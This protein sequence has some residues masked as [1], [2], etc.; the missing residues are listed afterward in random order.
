[1]L[2]SPLP[3]LVAVPV[4]PS[5]ELKVLVGRLTLRAFASTTSGAVPFL[6]NA[7][8]RNFN[9]KRVGRKVGPFSR[10]RLRLPALRRPVLFEFQK[11]IVGH[12]AVWTAWF[13]VE[14]LPAD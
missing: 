8:I 6:P 10:G 14:L 9:G 12:A 11:F 4:P 3:A 5:Q 1:M 2:P 7:E 13:P